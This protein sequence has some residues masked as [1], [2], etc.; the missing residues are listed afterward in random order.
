[1][2]MIAET[3]FKNIVSERRMVT[4]GREFGQLNEIQERKYF[5]L[6]TMLDEFN[7]EILSH[8]ML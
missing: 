8:G 3:V 5:V 2:G 4:P 7:P 1:M 6:R